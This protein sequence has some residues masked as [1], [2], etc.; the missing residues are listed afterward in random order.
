MIQV[1]LNQNQFDALIDFTYNE[2]TKHLQTSTLLKLLNQKNYSGASNEFAKWIYANG[3]VDEG[4]VTRRAKEAT[5]FR[6]L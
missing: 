2:G 1:P 3:E 4:L 6:S 5:L